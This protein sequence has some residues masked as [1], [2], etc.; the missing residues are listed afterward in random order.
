MRRKVIKEVYEDGY[1][2]GYMK[3]ID[4]FLEDLE[5]GLCTCG[6]GDI[7]SPYGDKLIEKWEGKKNET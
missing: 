6:C 1:V 7:V 5:K 3:A 2:E 4:E